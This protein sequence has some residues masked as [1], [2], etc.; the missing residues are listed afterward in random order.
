MFYEEKEISELILCPYCKNKYTDPRIVECSSCF[1]MPCIE[2]LTNNGEKGFKCPECDDF[3][4][5]PPKG[6]IKNPKLAKLCDK[7]A[8][9]V[10]RGS[11]ASSLGLQIDD[12]KLNLDELAN[13]NKL[14]IER[15]KE[16]CD[17]LR[18]VVQLSSEELIETIQTFNS[19][20]IE[21]INAYEKNSVLD[22]SQENKSAFDNF[23]NEM[24]AFH[25]KWSDYFKR[26][27]LDDSELIAASSEASKCLEQIKK[28]NAQVLDKVFN[29]RV[30]RFEKNQT[31]VKSNVVGTFNLSLTQMKTSLAPPAKNENVQ[32]NCLQHWSL[33]NRFN[34]YNFNEV[35]PLSIK[36]LNGGNFLV[37]C[38][39]SEYNKIEISIFDSNFDL[40]SKTINKKSANEMHRSSIRSS[41]QNV[42]TF[43]L[44]TL[45][46]NSIILSLFTRN[47]Y[48]NNYNNRNDSMDNSFEECEY[49]ENDY[50]YNDDNGNTLSLFK[51][52]NY[53][54]TVSKRIRLNYDVISIDTYD[55]QT[56]CLSAD[57][58][59][60]VYDCQ[61]S[62]LQ[63]IEQ[64]RSVM[65]SFRPNSKVR[66]KINISFLFFLN[67]T[68]IVLTS[69]NNARPI[70][71]FNIGSHDF[72]LNHL[73]NSILTY[74][75]ES[76]VVSYDFDGKSQT[77]DLNKANATESMQ[78]VDCSN[79]KLLFF[80]KA[81]LSFNVFKK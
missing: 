73:T 69:F 14:C 6:Y 79:D 39:S 55:N 63:R 22:F 1:C 74:D 24:Y 13:K 49:F 66:M 26:V 37:G 30:L 76:K 64:N 81:S 16:H 7:Q 19:E 56:Y 23:I 29:G 40:L 48:I 51:Q 45:A 77:F 10:S 35:E 47:Y 17:E 34:V 43:Q 9:P 75:G 42:Q 8:A 72:L 36:F 52:L 58:S 12:L 78:L 5:M 4:E 3:H 27:K 20:L 62:L 59:I 57:G 21:Q 41:Q 80:D 68:E 67:D 54:L 32:L 65:S 50:I 2:I 33:L 46:S 31:Q 44:N 53:Q 28:E 11:L 38:R 15:I 71:R 61:L 70:A 18:N 60:Y 25:A